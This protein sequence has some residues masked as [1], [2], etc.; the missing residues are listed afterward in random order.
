MMQI[1]GKFA[2]LHFLYLQQECFLIS[3]W[4]RIV[5]FVIICD[6]GESRIYILTG[7]YWCELC[8]VIFHSITILP[9]AKENVAV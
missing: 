3:K 8:I 4:K 2:V 5:V 6:I 9:K 7:K 1:V